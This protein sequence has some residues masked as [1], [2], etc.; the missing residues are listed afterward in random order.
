ML[1]IT[2]TDSFSYDSGG[3]VITGQPTFSEYEQ[4][5]RALFAHRRG[6]TFA[7]ADWINY[8]EARWG[9][10]Y[11]QALDVL[12]LEYS[13]LST[14]AYVGRK[15]ESSTRRENL[16]F[17][18][19]RAVAPLPP[20]EQCE[21]LALASDNEWTRE[22]TRAEVSRR[23][24]PDSPPQPDRETCPMCHGCGYLVKEPA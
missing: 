20:D 7:I 24:Q 15:V 5:G 9:E 23:R 3:L 18:H 17:S 16:S 22:E 21:V 13:T 12:D 11:A 19:H 10:K 6:V 1:P 4:A 14:Y 2:L 8:G